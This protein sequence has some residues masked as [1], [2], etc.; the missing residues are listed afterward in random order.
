MA[1]TVDSTTP[2]TD[3]SAHDGPFLT[4]QRIRILGIAA[5]VVA[6]IALAA[7]FAITA[8]KRKEAFA[9][10]ALEEAR[11]VAEQGNLP[12]AVQ[13]FEAV[14]KTYAG[15]SAAHEATLGMVQA[16]LVNGQSELAIATLTEFLA[17]NPPA[18]YAAPANALLGTAYENTGK[19]AEAMAAFRKA[20][21][22][23]TSD[24][25]KATYLLDAGRAARLAK[26]SAQATA[27]YGEI[28]E[29]YG[30]TAAK[31]EAEVRLA[32]MNRG[33]L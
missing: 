15:T 18:T 20:A 29:K 10:Q 17:A 14:T 31:T 21:E 33:T 2:T 1:T 12:L 6:V 32:E 30:E 22:L 26:D 23:G 7:W 9:A 8:G 3:A 28:I 13:Q 25:L 27:I 19:F 11:G 24:F 16:R 4:P 5:A